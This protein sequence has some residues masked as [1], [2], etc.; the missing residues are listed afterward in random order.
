MAPKVSC[1]WLN[2]PRNRV[3]VNNVMGLLNWLAHLANKSVVVGFIKF[4]N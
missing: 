4:K 2:F 3:A 1:E